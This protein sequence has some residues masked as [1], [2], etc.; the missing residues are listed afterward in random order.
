MPLDLRALLLVTLAVSVLFVLW[1][2]LDLAISHMAYGPDGFL[3]KQFPWVERLRLWLWDA[4][5]WV[6]GLVLVMTVLSVALRRPLLGL[7]RA[8]WAYALCVYLLGPGLLVNA[9]LKSYWGRARP[10]AVQDFGGDRLFSRAYEISNQCAANCSFVS[11]EVA[12]T[13]AMSVALWLVLQA[14]R[15]ALPRALHVALAVLV[16]ALPILS[17]LQRVFVGDHFAS[18][19]V[20][21]ALMTLVVAAWLWPRFR[22]AS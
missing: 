4:T 10:F 17:G 16:I 21:A 22:P 20:L 9:L 13:T 5:L 14:W 1:P 19:A 6:L 12:G 2:G 8:S 15:Q 7:P 18:D 3:L 11:G